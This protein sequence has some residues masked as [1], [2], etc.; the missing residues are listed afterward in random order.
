MNIA[1]IFYSLQGEG[2]TRGTPSIFIRLTG[3]NLT[4]GVQ[5]SICD[6]SKA[7]WVCDS[8]KVWNTQTEKLSSTQLWERLLSLV[9]LEDITSHRVH[10]VWT[11]GEPLL[12]KNA[13]D[14]KDFMV[15]VTEKGFNPY[16]EIETNGTID[17]E[18]SRWVLNR[19]NTINCS[20]K[21]SNSGIHKTSR[22]KESFLGF[23]RKFSF[24]WFK[25]VVTDKTQW[26]EIE[27]DFL[28][29]IDRCQ[30]ILMPGM[31]KLGEESLIVCQEVWN[32]A[33][34][35]K[36]RFSTREQITVWNKL[37]GV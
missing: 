21:L 12:T 29:H 3:C 35:Q 27:E 22:I 17:T 9:S 4:C 13:L 24:V 31:D 25:F 20:P 15:F 16:Y 32:L 36:V 30:V 7:T 5:S 11:G 34:T 14:I 19:I 8:F 1:E 37:T 10:I 28:P 2:V 18:D 6:I 33:Q 26:K 23:V